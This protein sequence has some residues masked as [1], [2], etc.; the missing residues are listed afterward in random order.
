MQVWLDLISHNVFDPLQKDFEN[1]AAEC[2][3]AVRGAFRQLKELAE[4]QGE[5]L[6]Q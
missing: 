6:L 2:R 3:D 4:R 5:S 1:V